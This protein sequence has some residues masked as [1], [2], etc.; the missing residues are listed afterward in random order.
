LLSAFEVPMPNCPA[1][2]T[3]LIE[4]LGH[5]DLIGHAEVL[6]QLRAWL[7]LPRRAERATARRS[8]PEPVSRGAGRDRRR[9]RPAPC[10]PTAS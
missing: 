7:G 4:D 8:R 3:R 5:L 10:R 6:A 1:G 9:R 2:H